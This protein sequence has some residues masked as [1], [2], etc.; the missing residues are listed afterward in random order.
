ME[1]QL[2]PQTFIQIEWANPAIHK[3]RIAQ[4]KL[5]FEF[6]IHSI[7]WILPEC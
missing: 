4:I 7:V 5:M 3:A 2:A 6:P 1:D